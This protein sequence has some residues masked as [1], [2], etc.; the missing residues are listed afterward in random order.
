MTYGI[1]IPCR[2]SNP[3]TGSVCHCCLRWYH[4]LPWTRAILACAWFFSVLPGKFY[5]LSW[6]FYHRFLSNSLHSFR[7][8]LAWCPAGAFR[9]NVYTTPDKLCSHSRGTISNRGRAVAFSRF[10]SVPPDKHQ[11]RVLI[12]THTSVHERSINQSPSVTVFIIAV[13]RL[14]HLQD[15]CCSLCTWPTSDTKA[16]GVIRI[17]FAVF[18]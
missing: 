10:F 7:F 16:V 17:Q 15:T 18:W 1:V 12:R 8:P 6:N 2:D 4:F 11:D 9:V 3:R 5:V 13:D 14:F